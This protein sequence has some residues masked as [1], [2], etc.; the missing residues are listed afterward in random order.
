MAKEETPTQNDALETLQ[1]QFKFSELRNL[2]GIVVAAGALLS[3]AGF[4]IVNASLSQFGT[5]QGFSVIPGRYLAASFWFGVAALVGLGPAAIGWRMSRGR[6]VLATVI[7]VV[8]YIGLWRFH[9]PLFNLILSIDA[10]LNLEPIPVADILALLVVAVI[11]M[12][13][14]VLIRLYYVLY[15]QAKPINRRTLVVLT[16]KPGTLFWLVMSVLVMTIII[17]SL[18]S[19]IIYPLFPQSLGGGKPSSAIFILKSEEDA[20]LL[21]LPIAPSETLI[22]EP[23]LI[24]SELTNG[25]LVHDEAQNL[26]VIIKH[27]SIRAI[28]DAGMPTVTPMPPVTPTP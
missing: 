10:F 27:D 3:A 15:G 7:A 5:I 16:Q 25:Y 4:L 28:I 11:P 6:E 17:I 18:F 13:G 21:P 20:E 1:S 8:L 14:G 26:T 9:D 12:V 24:I 19:T 22:T 2:I 23:V